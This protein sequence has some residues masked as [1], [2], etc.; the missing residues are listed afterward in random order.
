MSNFW[1]N[2]PEIETALAEVKAYIREAIDDAE[3]MIKTPILEVLDAGGKMLRPALV[4]IGAGFGKAERER[5][6]PIAA[7]VELLHMA[8]LIHDDIIDEA[9]LRRGVESVQSKYTKQVAVLVGDYIFAKTFDLLAGDYPAEMLKQLSGSILKICQGE[10]SQF[11]NRYNQDITYDDF[12][13]IIAGKTAALFS[14]SLFSGAFE[15]KAKQTDIQRLVKVGYCLGMMFQI[16]DDCLDYSGDE[17][18]LGKSAVN[19]IKQGYITLPLFFALQAENGNQLHKLVF[20]S[21]LSDEDI[22]R[23]KALVI[24]NGGLNMAKEKV[25]SYAE[26]AKE[27]LKRLKKNKDRKAL[28]YLIEAFVHREK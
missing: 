17:T 14:M 7:S 16:V 5:I 1:E 13:E 4:M 25:Q 10:L 9:A 20:E 23:I 24:E 2:Y 27:A 11:T 15:A 8:T 18:T 19:D 21:E 12:V 6:I 22:A 3:P 28:G 26:D